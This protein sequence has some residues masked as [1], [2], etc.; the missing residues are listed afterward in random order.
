MEISKMKLRKWLFMKRAGALN[1]RTI[2]KYFAKD[3]DYF[4]MYKEVFIRL[5]NY[6]Q[7]DSSEAQK[8]AVA[9]DLFAD[10]MLDDIHR[11]YGREIWLSVR[12]RITY[13]NQQSNY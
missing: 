8:H 10:L 5:S 3:D 1:T 13:I 6:M 7:E 2:A 11:V 4:A 12:T 9:H